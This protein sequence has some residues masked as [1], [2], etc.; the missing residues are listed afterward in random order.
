LT[1]L[2]EGFVNVAAS[3]AKRTG[4]TAAALRDVGVPARVLAR[5]SL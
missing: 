4:I 5:A 2:Q 1:E 3:S